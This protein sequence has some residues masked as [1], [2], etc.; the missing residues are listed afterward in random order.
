VCLCFNISGAGA[1]RNEIH[2][3]AIDSAALPL[4]LRNV[5]HTRAPINPDLLPR[6]ADAPSEQSK[7]II[8][9]VCR[10][11]LL[12]FDAADGKRY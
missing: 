3:A 12:K 10:A 11:F 9:I 7:F 6:A 1:P 4:V 8:F 5:I 2:P